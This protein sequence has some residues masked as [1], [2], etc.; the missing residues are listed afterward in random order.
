M[1]AEILQEKCV[2]SSGSVPRLAL[3]IQIGDAMIAATCAVLL[4]RTRVVTTAFAGW[5]I[6]LPYCQIKLSFQTRPCNGSLYGEEPDTT[7]QWLLEKCKISPYA[8]SVSSQGQVD[9]DLQIQSKI[10]EKSVAAMMQVGH[11]DKLKCQ[12]ILSKFSKG[13]KLIT[14]YWNTHQGKWQTQTTYFDI[15]RGI[16][17]QHFCSPC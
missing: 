9:L 5:Y 7:T 1:R 4:S 17:L 8:S 13:W 6:L 16:F 3:T 15:I 14:Y 2:C 11:S 10:P 12:F